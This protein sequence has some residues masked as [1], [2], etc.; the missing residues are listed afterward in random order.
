MLEGLVAEKFT[1][2]ENAIGGGSEI[3]FAFVDL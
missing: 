2:D 1:I 3:Q